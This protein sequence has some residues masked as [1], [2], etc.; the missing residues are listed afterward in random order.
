MEKVVKIVSRDDAGFDAAFWKTKSP[1]ER[2]LALE[3]LRSQYLTKNR[4]RQRLQRVCR[5]VERTP[6]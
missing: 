2:I 5:V 4:I 3:S 6:N 1:V